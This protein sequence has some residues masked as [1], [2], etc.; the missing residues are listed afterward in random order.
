MNNIQ[1]KPAIKWASALWNS[2]LVTILSYIAYM[3]PAFVVAFK[4]GFELGPKLQDPAEVSRQISQAIPPIYQHN[5]LLVLGFII[6]TAL[7]I[8]WRGRR[9]A[10]GTG[11]K[12]MINGVLVSTIPVLLT[13][14]FLFSRGFQIRSVVEI[15]IY[16]LT[17]YVSGKMAKNSLPTPAQHPDPNN[18]S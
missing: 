10:A 9:I 17:G 6:V 1:K 2:L 12:S 16:L 3:I 13:V 15:I 11:E 18:L 7:L 8:F 4:M 14:M 5:Q